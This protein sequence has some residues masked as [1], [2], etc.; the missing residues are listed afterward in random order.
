MGT[1]NNPSTGWVIAEV[2]AIVLSAAIV[3][4]CSAIIALDVAP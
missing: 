1:K 3:M 4:V 2:V